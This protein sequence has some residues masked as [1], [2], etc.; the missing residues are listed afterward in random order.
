[1]LPYHRID[2]AN[3]IFTNTFDCISVP[4]VCLYSIYMY[5]LSLGFVIGD[6]NH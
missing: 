6:C 4:N 5:V 3:Y 1:M 2:H